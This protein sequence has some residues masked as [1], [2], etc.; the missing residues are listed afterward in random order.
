MRK[1]FLALALVI[2]FSAFG[3]EKK[4]KLPEG[5]TL[6]IH[7]EDKNHKVLKQ[8]FE[9]ENHKVFSTMDSIYK[10]NPLKYKYQY[11][12]Y[13]VVDTLGKVHYSREW[14]YK[15]EDKDFYI[16]KSQI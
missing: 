1:L 16:K 7:I 11:L 3:Q 9:N 14:L 8:L 10:T 5:M 6:L 2:G 12:H 13:I 4:L 15:K